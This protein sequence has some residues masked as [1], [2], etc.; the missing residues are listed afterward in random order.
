MT[1][2]GT[3]LRR[4]ARAAITLAAAAALVGLL[5]TSSQANVNRYTVQPSSPKPTVCNNSGTIPAGTW[6]QNA[7]CG[8]WVGT[9]MAGSSFDV[10]QTNPSNYHYGRSLGG[11][12]ICGWIPPGALG[13]SPT[14][15]V[16]ES[17]SDATKDNISHR[18]T[19]GYNF[20]A[21]AH[22]ATDGTAITVNPAC[23]AY[24]NYY[25]TSTYN[26]GSLRDVAGNP[27]TTV[28]YRFT[29]NG[30]NPAIVVRDSAIGWIFLNRSCVTDWRSITFYNDND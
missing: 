19:I 15:S 29:T 6:L 24:Y 27:G 10:H 11:N 7:P 14:A 8:Y 22:A 2:I 30:S 23:T 9:A 25:T 21:A 12:N 18:R 28:M 1:T 3:T 26:D 20:N 4:R 17:C 5:P 16:A 13:S